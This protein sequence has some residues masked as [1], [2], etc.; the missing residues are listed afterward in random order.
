MPRGRVKVDADL[1]NNNLL[2]LLDQVA[3]P[4]L[5]DTTLAPPTVGRDPAIVSWNGVAKDLSMLGRSRA[6]FDAGAIAR[7]Q[8]IPIDRYYAT[9]T[10]IL[11]E[12]DCVDYL[13]RLRSDLVDAIFADPPFNLGKS[14]GRRTNDSRADREYVEW[15]RRWLAECVRVLSPGGALFVYNLPRWSIVLGA[16][17]MELP[18]MEFRH[19]IAI[20]MKSCLP[21]PGRLYPAHYSLHYFTKGKPKTFR[22]IRTPI[23]TCRHCNGEI[24]DYGGHR[25]AMNPLGVN[26]KD[27]WTDIPPVRHWRFKSRKRPAIALSTK[28]LER[29]IEMTTKP[30]DLVLGPFGG[31]GTTYAVCEARGRRWVGIELDSCP[32]IVERLQQRAI[33]HHRNED[34]VDEV[35]MRA[36]AWPAAAD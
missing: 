31:S 35:H 11:F 4:P 10:G 23:E 1:P 18:E 16:Y 32:A 13:S 5:R 25:G 15:C 22:K 28:V 26:L 29:A 7:S 20:E 30:G 8:D 36:A 19:S 34:I 6:R 17:L 9:E 27:V 2:D 12:G 3:A 24:R 33:D 21:I 14:Y